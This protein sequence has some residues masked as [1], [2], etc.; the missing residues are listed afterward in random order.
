MKSLRAQKKEKRKKKK[1]KTRELGSM[2]NLNPLQIHSLK[3]YNQ[4]S[5]PA[6]LSAGVE[7]AV[8]SLV[9]NALPKVGIEEPDQG[10]GG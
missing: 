10:C 7:E 3:Q 2:M 6:C 1:E 9:K 8:K 4:Q 5:K